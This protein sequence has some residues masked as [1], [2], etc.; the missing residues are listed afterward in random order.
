MAN[1]WRSSKT[2]QAS[3]VIL[4]YP[5]DINTRYGACSTERSSW[6]AYCNSFRTCTFDA[7]EGLQ[8]LCWMTWRAKIGRIREQN[9]PL[10][11]PKEGLA[12]E[13]ILPRKPPAEYFVRRQVIILLEN[14]SWDTGE[15]RLP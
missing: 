5:F 10:F 9:E 11:G 6:I 7:K 12:P 15:L 2:W 8:E 4:W 3:G 13:A 14:E 1:S